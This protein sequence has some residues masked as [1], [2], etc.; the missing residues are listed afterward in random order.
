MKPVDVNPI[1]LDGRHYD[2]QCKDFTEDIAFWIRQ[3]RKYGGPILEL[4]CGIGRITLPLAKEGFKITGLDI[5]ES[6]LAEA[7]KKIFC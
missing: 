2:L 1:Y 6:M 4:A 3:A 7:E 5:A